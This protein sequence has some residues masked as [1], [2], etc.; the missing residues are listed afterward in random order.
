MRWAGCLVKPVSL[1]WDE[2]EGRNFV[3]PAVNGG[4]WVWEV[5]H[6]PN[7]AQDLLGRHFR[8]LDIRTGSK[9]ATWEDGI[10][11]R[12]LNTGKEVEYRRGKIYTRRKGKTRKKSKIRRKG[13]ARKKSKTRKKGQ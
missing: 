10:R 2:E 6:D 1:P 4:Q 7:P 5:V 12:N 11:F 8:W 3:P 13:K 9:L